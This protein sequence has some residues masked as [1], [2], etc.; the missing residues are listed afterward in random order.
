MSATTILLSATVMLA[1][2]MIGIVWF[3]KYAF[4]ELSNKLSQE[5]LP[6]SAGFAPVFKKDF[7]LACLFTL[8]IQPIAG[9]CEIALLILLAQTN[10]VPLY[11]IC[12]GFLLTIACI[13]IPFSFHQK[14]PSISQKKD[15]SPI[16]DA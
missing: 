10:T 8:I 4:L 2:V 15:S 7:Q 5:G 14:E 3:I 6:V 16:G 9:I 12:I 11:F 13:I 1:I